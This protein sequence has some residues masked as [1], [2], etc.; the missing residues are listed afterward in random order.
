MKKD[1]KREITFVLNGVSPN[2][3][4]R[5][6]AAI[7]YGLLH[8]ILTK[9]PD[10]KIYFFTNSGLNE[11]EI[12]IDDKNII[13]HYFGGRLRNRVKHLFFSYIYKYM[14]KKIKM[15]MV[16]KNNMLKIF[17]SA[18]YII[19]ISHGDGFTDLY[20]IS[21]LLDYQIAIIIGSNLDVPIIKFPQ[22]IGP[23]NTLI[24]KIYAKYI[25]NKVNLIM[26][27]ELCSEDII[28][29]IGVSYKTIKVPDLAFL[30]PPD[31]SA[32][33]NCIVSGHNGLE[34]N[35]LVGFN[36]SGLL[37]NF[38]NTKKYLKKE[39]N[40]LVL[41]ENIIKTLIIDYNAVI[42]I[43]P[44]D[45]EYSNET[46]SDDLKYSKLIYKKMYIK[47]PKRIFLINGNYN[48]RQIK[49][50]ISGLDFF[51]GSRMHACIAA[52]SQCIP[53]VPI[54]YSYK[55]K[56]VWESIDL[57]GLVADPKILNESD[58]LKKI[59]IAIDY[60]ETTRQKLL[61]IMPII[62]SEILKCKN[63]I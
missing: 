45:Y 49:G 4:N 9:Y 23:F 16:Q 1:E 56:G 32:N 43:V 63:Y 47:F 22:T 26:I 24:G 40:Y 25:L 39:M 53:T 28:Q 61:N 54:S 37:S 38:G 12:K 14:N 51:I 5:G 55:F 13:I 52:V 3:R 62:K 29:N 10:A 21:F 34:N 20:R 18:S 17:K 2:A 46:I 57:Q 6:I 31:K 58:I 11:D 35:L 7:C 41:I 60:R 59:C 48:A 8:I 15:L 33:I 44:H 50:Y 36:I 27:R 19:D 42:I 30:M